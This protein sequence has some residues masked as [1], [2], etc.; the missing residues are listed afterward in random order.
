MK[1]SAFDFIND[2]IT[3]KHKVIETIVDDK[4]TILLKDKTK[5]KSSYRSLPLMPEIKEALLLHKKKIERNRRLCGNSYITEYKD[6]ICVNE[7]GK[8]FRP[9][10]ITDHFSLLLKKQK[11]R[12]ICFHRITTFVC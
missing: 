6:Y 11:L 2:T 1:W 10:Y 12:H 4:R 9:E 8:I 7:I 5:N 3:I